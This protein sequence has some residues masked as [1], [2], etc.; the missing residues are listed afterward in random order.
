MTSTNWKEII[1]T[2][3]KNNNISFDTFLNDNPDILPPR[4]HI[5]RCFEYFNIEQT[6]VV[7]IGQDP[8]HNE[9][10][11]TGLA[12]DCVSKIPPSLRNIFKVLGAG[13][14][15]PQE[16]GK[17]S[18]LESWAKQGV[19]LLNASLTVKK[20][21]PGS[22]MKYWLPFTKF[23]IEMIDRSVEN[24]LFVCWGAFAKDLCINVKN[25]L[26]SSHP[27]PLSA[28]RQL[29]DFPSFME[30]DVFNRINAYLIEKKL[31]PIE[32]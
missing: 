27:S 6:K 30:S 13:A 20:N 15:I 32:F 18:N 5:F 23:I 21:T 25:K 19:L 8:Y 3:Q 12:F 4:Q 16:V 14:T 17:H 1:E 11:A 26:I 10:E 28:T 7:I 29:G 22:H 24:V 9:G 2:Y 31:K